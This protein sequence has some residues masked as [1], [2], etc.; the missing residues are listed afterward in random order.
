M[1]SLNAAIPEYSDTV[2]AESAWSACCQV[3]DVNPTFTYSRRVIAPCSVCR[4]GWNRTNCHAIQHVLPESHVSPWIIAPIWSIANPRCTY[5][6]L[7]QFFE[8]VNL[9]TQYS[10]LLLD[11]L[12]E[13]VQQ[14][15]VHSHLVILYQS[16]YG[17]D[18]LR[19]SLCCQTQQT[20][21]TRCLPDY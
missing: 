15:H 18:W 5:T 10:N 6:I 19:Q 20:G 14:Q 21:R 11:A 4:H 9:V 3:P 1:L 8:K 2:P 12:P 13:I 16:S 17:Q 7:P